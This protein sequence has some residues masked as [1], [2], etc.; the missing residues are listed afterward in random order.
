MA[1]WTKTPPTGTSGAMT[2]MEMVSGTG[3]PRSSPASHLR[4]VVRDCGDCNDANAA[5]N[6]DAEEDCS[7]VDDEDCDGSVDKNGALNCVIYYRDPDDDGYGRQESSRC[8]CVDPG[9]DYVTE[10]GDC[11]EGDPLV[12]PGA[13]DVCEDGLDTNCDGWDVCGQEIAGIEIRGEPGSHAGYAVAVAGDQTGDGVPDILLGAVG[14][15]ADPGAAYLFSGDLSESIELASAVLVMNGVTEGDRA[16]SA[17]SG[18]LDMDGDGWPD[19]L[20]GAPYNGKQDINNGVAYLVYGGDSGSL[21]LADSGAIISAGGEY[22]RVGQK[23][24]L[25]LAQDL[26]GDGA[27]DIVLGSPALD[28]RT[29]VVVVSDG[30]VV[31]QADARDMGFLLEGGRPHDG[32]GSAVLASADFDGDGSVDLVIGCPRSSRLAPNAGGFYVFDGPIQHDTRAGDADAQS[33]SI[34][35][36]QLAGFTLA[37]AGDTNGDGH[38][39]LLVGGMGRGGEV[40]LSEDPLHAPRDLGETPIQIHGADGTSGADE[41]PG[42]FASALAGG[43]DLDGNGRPDVVIGAPLSTMGQGHIGLVFVFTDP[44]PGVYEATDAATI[45]YGPEP[46]DAAGYSLTTPGDL[47][48]DG[49]D[50]LLV[51]APGLSEGGQDGRAWLV[52]G[53][54][55]W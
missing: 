38:P 25:Q 53:C 40:W 7:T 4:W 36:H 41:N 18:G 44:V 24:T 52:S 5:V 55:V 22:A 42:D 35:E 32:F 33:M 31:G 9:S 15:G 45:L 27:P 12:N 48:G 16:G 29:G 11:D 14:E 8:A 20:I 13:A 37:S 51:G 43:L 34:D 46:E 54:T 2:P 39:D 49:C 19:L 30:P 23:G 47:D 10:G 17:V 6:P 3:G 50:D 26:S 28:T 21:S 1:R